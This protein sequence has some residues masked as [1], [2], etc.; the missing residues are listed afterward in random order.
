MWG[1]VGSDIYDW[2]GDVMIYKDWWGDYFLGYVRRLSGSFLVLAGSLMGRWGILG[3]FNG[4]DG[5][6]GSR[7][8]NRVLDKVPRGWGCQVFMRVCSGSWAGS[9]DTWICYECFGGTGGFLKWFQVKG[10]QECLRDILGCLSRF[11]REFKDILLSHKSNS[12]AWGFLLND[13]M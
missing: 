7:G 4:F 3:G 11:L 12:Y 2:T 8:G 9:R 6:S 5:C 13:E 1:L 10:L